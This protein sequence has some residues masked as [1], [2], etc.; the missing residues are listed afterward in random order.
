MPQP[1]EPL[2]YNRAH[3]T[4]PGLVHAPGKLEESPWWNPVKQAVF[5]TNAGYGG[6]ESLAIVTWNSG[7]PDPI[8]SVRGHTLGWFERSLA[9]FGVPHVVLGG[10]IGAAWNNRMKLDLTIEFLARSNREFVLGGDSSD[11]LLVADPRTMVD[12]CRR[13]GARVL[14]NAEKHQWPREARETARFE[15]RV[16]RGPF[17]YLN[18]GLWIGRREDCLR[19]FQSARRWADQLTAHLRSDQICWKYAYRE[20]YPAIQVDW[21]C[22]VFQNLNRVDREIEVRGQSLPRTRSLFHSMVGALT[23][24]RS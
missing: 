20:L 13:H 2:V 9:H 11:V 10:D 21:Q 15:R 17:R 19:A 6:C 16:S 3:R 14:F 18:S 1:D 7:A 24:R 5:A 4:T 23:S 22:R 8:L 12:A